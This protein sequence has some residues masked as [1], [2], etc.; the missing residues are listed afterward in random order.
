MTLNPVAD[1]VYPLGEGG[2]IDLG[3]RHFAMPFRTETTDCYLWWHDCSRARAWCFIGPL[4]QSPASG[5]VITSVD[6]LTVSGAL[7][8]PSGCGDHGCIEAGRWRPE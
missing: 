6:P 7:L 1:T 5:P 4:G 2:V 8:C 3:D